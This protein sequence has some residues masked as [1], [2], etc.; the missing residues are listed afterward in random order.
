[1]HRL[2]LT[3]IR[4]ER[5]LSLR[6]LKNRSGVALSALAKMEGGGGDPQL[7]T[8][9]KLAKALRCTVG[10]LIGEAKRKKGG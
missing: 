8:L 4:K 1:M 3:A 9:K 2:R 5:G 7:S 6:A 10:E